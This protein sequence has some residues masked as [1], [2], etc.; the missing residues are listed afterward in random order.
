MIPDK[1]LNLTYSKHAI[2]ERCFDKYG[3]I[4]QAPKNFFRTGCKSAVQERDEIIKA[5]YIYDD[6]FDIILVIN[7]VLNLVITNYLKPA[8]NKGVF[9]GRYRLQTNVLRNLPRRRS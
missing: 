1:I 6:D 5:T 9:K 8:I 7:T 2:R 3:S 4:T